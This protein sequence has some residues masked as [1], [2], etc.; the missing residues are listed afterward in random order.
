MEEDWFDWLVSY[1]TDL[2]VDLTH[3]LT[4][5]LLSPAA[6]ESDGLFSKELLF[7]DFF[8]SSFSRLLRPRRL[9]LGLLFFL[10]FSFG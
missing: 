9:K 8:L 10:I 4:H 2:L 6:A 1:D 5:E 7:F 3:F